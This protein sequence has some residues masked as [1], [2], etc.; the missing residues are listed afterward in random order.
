MYQALHTSK[1][2]DVYNAISAILSGE[3]IL[4]SEKFNHF[5]LQEQA[6]IHTLRI[7]LFYEISLSLR[8][9][10]CFRSLFISLLALSHQRRERI[11]KA[12]DLSVRITCISRQPLSCRGRRA[13]S[14]IR[15]ML[16][17]MSN[18]F[19]SINSSL[20]A[21]VQVVLVVVVEKLAKKERNLI[22]F[23]FRSPFYVA[24]TRR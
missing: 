19:P 14:F 22:S 10:T 24:A 4:S 1:Y 11:L 13:F 6:P 16:F 17:S 20:L 23:H 8:L 7:T 9:S 5:R 15:E 18:S 12:E 3:H 2:D 21:F